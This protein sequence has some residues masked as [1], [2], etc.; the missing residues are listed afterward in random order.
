MKKTKTLTCTFYVGGKQVEKLTEEQKEK[1][2]QRFGEAL[3]KYYSLHPEE[4]KK[5]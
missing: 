2:A 3:S 4:Y 5:L 1:M